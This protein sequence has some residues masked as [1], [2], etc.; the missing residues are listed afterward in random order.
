MR[1]TQIQIAFTPAA[2]ARLNP[3]GK[4]LAKIE[5][6]WLRTGKTPAGV[7]VRPKVWG[8]K[9]SAPTARKLLTASDEWGL[10]KREHVAGITLCDYDEPAQP[11]ALT[12]IWRL[13]A[14][15]DMIPEWCEYDRTRHGWHLIIRWD[16]ELSPAETV[17]IQLLL[18][19]DANRETFNLQRVLTGDINPRWNILFHRKL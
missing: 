16:R 12:D 18:G 11:P 3:D 9:T 15:L 4:M 8:R 6:D 17:C 2:H 13:A 10:V 19:S 5:R 7:T 1:S 14:R